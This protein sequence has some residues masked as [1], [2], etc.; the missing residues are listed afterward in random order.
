MQINEGTDEAMPYDI[1]KAVFTGKSGNTV[2]MHYP[3][4][5]GFTTIKKPSATMFK[6]AFSSADTANLGAGE[7]NAKIECIIT[8]PDAPEGKWVEIV[9]LDMFLLKK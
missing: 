2:E 5:T 6:Y 7:V 8:D 9:E 1:I 3:A 4:E